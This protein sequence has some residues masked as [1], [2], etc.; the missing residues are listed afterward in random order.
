MP[1]LE[2]FCLSIHPGENQ[3]QLLLREMMKRMSMKMTNT[4][5]GTSNGIGDVMGFSEHSG[6][7]SAINYGMMCSSRSSTQWGLQSGHSSSEKHFW[8]C[9]N[10]SASMLE[11]IEAICLLSD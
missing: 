7:S 4:T 1:N 5:W 2:G 11:N 10:H 9:S 8:D 3:R 6:T